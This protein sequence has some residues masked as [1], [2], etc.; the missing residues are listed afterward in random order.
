MNENQN[1]T[2]NK[3]KMQRNDIN[4]RKNVTYKHKIKRKYNAMTSM[5]EK[6]VPYNEINFLASSRLCLWWNLVF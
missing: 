1:E 3:T 5:K 6:N 4:E 2:E